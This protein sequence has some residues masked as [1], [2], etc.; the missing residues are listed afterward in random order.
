MYT[1]V[2][3]E[4]TLFANKVTGDDIGNGKIRIH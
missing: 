2:A 3:N 1:A 4:F